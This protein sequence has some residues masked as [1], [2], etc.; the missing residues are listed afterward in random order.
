V[1]QRIL[2][3]T[4]DNVSRRTTTAV[5]D[6]APP[7]HFDTYS[8]DAELKLFSRTTCQRLFT[9]AEHAAQHAGRYLFTLLPAPPAAVPTAYYCFYLHQRLITYRSRDV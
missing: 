3:P 7:R 9:M 1:Q 2:T 5:S 6:A 4:G 8:L